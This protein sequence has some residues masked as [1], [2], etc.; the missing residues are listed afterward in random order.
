MEPSWWRGGRPG[1]GQVRRV[2]GLLAPGTRPTLLLGTESW[3]HFLGGGGFWRGGFGWGTGGG[4]I[5]PLSD[6]RSE[7]QEKRG[8]NR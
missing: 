5:R 3:R 2:R 6:I 7:R 8:E 4:E 1:G